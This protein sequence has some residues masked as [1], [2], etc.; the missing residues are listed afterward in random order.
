MYKQLEGCNIKNI[1]QNPVKIHDKEFVF[2]CCNATG[3]LKH[4]YVYANRS[5]MQSICEWA[6]KDDTFN[7]NKVFNMDKPM[8]LPLRISLLNSLG[9]R[10]VNHLKF[11]VIPDIIEEH[12][13]HTDGSGIILSENVVRKIIE[14][15][16]K[17]FFTTGYPV[18]I[19]TSEEIINTS[20]KRLIFLPITNIRKG[21]P[22][23]CQISLQSIQI[24]FLVYFKFDLEDSKEC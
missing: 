20:T 15:Y 4:K 11:K 17:N 3:A 12:A 9:I 8:T 24:T 22:M 10:T 1:L 16:K 23:T 2:L 5:I 21:C 13:N 18:G 14:A 19:N 7:A 6:F